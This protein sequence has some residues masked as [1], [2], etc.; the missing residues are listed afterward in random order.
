ML[1]ASKYSAVLDW[2]DRMEMLYHRYRHPGIRF[3]DI[4]R[5]QVFTIRWPV[6]RMP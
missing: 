1:G 6:I 2:S 5:N 3:T 4:E